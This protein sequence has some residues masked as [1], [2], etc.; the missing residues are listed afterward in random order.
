MAPNL[1]DIEL[2]AADGTL[3]HAWWMWPTTW[4]KA[5]IQQRPT[6]CFFQAGPCLCRF[7]HT[8]A[9]YLSATHPGH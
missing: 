6:V 9:G 3:L 5:Q 2:S 7:V 8:A 1:Q 4:S